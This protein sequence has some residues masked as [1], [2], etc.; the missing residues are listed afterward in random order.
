MHTPTI[1][2]N[3]GILSTLLELCAGA[4]CRKWLPELS[5]LP[6]KCLH[7]PWRASADVLSK[8]GVEL[9]QHYPQRIV[10]D[11]AAARTRTVAALLEARRSALDM[12]DSGGYDLITLPSGEKTCV[13]TKHEFR[14]DANGVVKKRPVG[15]KGNGRGPKGTPKRG[16]SAPKANNTQPQID[17][18]LIK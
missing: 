7:T 3:K 14:L 1:C 6:N 15:G 2:I 5:K 9:G 12:N 17:R 4:Y 11:L 13:F 10:P 16:R 8:A 18:F